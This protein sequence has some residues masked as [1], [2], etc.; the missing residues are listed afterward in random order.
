VAIPAGYTTGGA[1]TLTEDLELALA[2]I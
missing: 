2:A 1:V